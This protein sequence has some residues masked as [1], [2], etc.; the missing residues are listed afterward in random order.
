ML[1]KPGN[2]VLNTTVTNTQTLYLFLLHMYS[3]YSTFIV[4]YIRIARYDFANSIL[5]FA[6]CKYS[7]QLPSH[8]SELWVYVYTAVY[9]VIKSIVQCTLCTLYNV[10][11]T[12]YYACIPLFYSKNKIVCIT[13]FSLKI[14]GPNTLLAPRPPPPIADPM[15]KTES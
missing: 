3:Y 10:H 12:M 4:P 2:E 1:G 6:Y 13:E 15:V 11:C 8:S 5:Y 7:E 14:G 9:P